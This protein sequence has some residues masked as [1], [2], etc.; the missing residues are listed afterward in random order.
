MPSQYPDPCDYCGHAAKYHT[1][2]KG[3]RLIIEIGSVNVVCD[4][5]R[6]WY[7]PELLSD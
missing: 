7:K 2:G 6:L 1:N 5:E 4:C 3:C